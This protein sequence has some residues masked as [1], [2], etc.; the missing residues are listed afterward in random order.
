MPLTTTLVSKMC[1][2]FA[3][4]RRGLSDR[5]A[6]FKSKSPV[7]GDME[8]SD[9]M[10]SEYTLTRA[11]PL[12]DLSGSLVPTTCGYPYSGANTEELPKPQAC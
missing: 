12:C 11:E 10:I 9:R 8:R 2:G 3:R 4:P 6:D 5:F 1:D 7:S